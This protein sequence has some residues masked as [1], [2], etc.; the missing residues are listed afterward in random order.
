MLYH[1]GLVFRKE[2]GKKKILIKIWTFSK[3]L[4][5]FKKNTNVWNTSKHTGF[6]D[7]FILFCFF[8][9]GFFCF[10]YSCYMLFILTVWTILWFPL[11]INI[12]LKFIRFFFI[13]L[14]WANYFFF[15]K[16]KKKKYLVYCTSNRFVPICRLS[17]VFL[18]FIFFTVHLI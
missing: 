12:K 16:K 15:K 18:F 13:S 11:E 5:L 6:Y 4:R 10:S 8:E 9:G 1:I 14:T 3:S 17:G 2:N 7:L